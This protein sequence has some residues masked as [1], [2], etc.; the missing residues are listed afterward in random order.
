MIKTKLSILL[1]VTFFMTTIPTYSVKIELTP[2]RLNNYVYYEIL[3]KIRSILSTE[4]KNIVVVEE[5]SKKLVFEYNGQRYTTKNLVQGV[6]HVEMPEG[7]K[8][9]YLTRTTTPA[10]L[11]AQ[12]INLSIRNING[13]IV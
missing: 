2:F 11:L 9:R 7:L 10:L 4:F 1:L 6:I 5:N 13:G 8:D 3:Y 12:L